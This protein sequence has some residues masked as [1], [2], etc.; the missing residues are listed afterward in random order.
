MPRRAQWQVFE[1]QEQPAPCS[2]LIVKSTGWAFK[3]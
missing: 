1:R 3:K 2:A